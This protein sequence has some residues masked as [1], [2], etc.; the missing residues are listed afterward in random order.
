MTANRKVMLLR[1]LADKKRQYEEYA[2]AQKH[3]ENAAK[4]SKVINR[5]DNAMAKIRKELLEETEAYIE[6]HKIKIAKEKEL[7]EKQVRR[8]QRKEAWK[9]EMERIRRLHARSD[10]TAPLAWAV[11]IAIATSVGLAFWAWSQ[12]IL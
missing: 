4:A 8:K 7:R 11:L 1:S 5:I 3:P 2:K 9:R 10:E 6:Q 12:G